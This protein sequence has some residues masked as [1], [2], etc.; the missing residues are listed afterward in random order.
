MRHPTMNGIVSLVS[1]SAATDD[2]VHMTSESERDEVHY[3]Q[4]PCP[5][6]DLCT[7]IHETNDIAHK[8]SKDQERMISSGTPY[9]L[10]DPRI[11]DMLKKM[12]RRVG[13]QEADRNSQHV[14]NN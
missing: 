2:G 3:R 14:E 11:K 4:Q 9:I 7:I 5:L 8:E 12:V 10:V 6:Q 1:K 13:T